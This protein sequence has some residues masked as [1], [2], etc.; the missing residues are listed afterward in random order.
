MATNT[1]TIIVDFTD[2]TIK[3]Y[4]D[5]PIKL[6]DDKETAGRLITARAKKNYPNKQI[7]TWVVEDGIAYIAPQ[8]DQEIADAQDFPGAFILSKNANRVIT[9]KDILST[10]GGLIAQGGLTEKE[11]VQNMR[12]LAINIVDPIKKKYPSMKI[13]SGFRNKGK[14]VKD[15]QTG[16]IVS[17]ANSD[18][19][20]GSAVD[21]GFQKPHS[22]YIAIATWISKNIPHKQLLLEHNINPEGV[23]FSSW[24]HIAFALD[25]GGKLIRSASPVATITNGGVKNGGTFKPGLLALA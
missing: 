19:D 12:N 15:P 4:T 1:T 18:H 8:V 11:L 23:I 2:N 17:S 14:P 3:P 24:I 21:L 10:S 25:Q 9:L 5:F 13:N 6:L 7:Q 20:L 22:E 16:K